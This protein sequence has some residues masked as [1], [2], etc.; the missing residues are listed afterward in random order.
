MN[1]SSI[2][3]SFFIILIQLSLKI[4]ICGG[5]NTAH[6]SSAVIS[7]NSN[8]KV[9]VFTRRPHLWNKAIVAHTKGSMWENKGDI[10][11]I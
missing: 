8:Y 1:P 4:T 10:I 11:G 3:V 6:F 9:N 5:G 2:Q 7:S